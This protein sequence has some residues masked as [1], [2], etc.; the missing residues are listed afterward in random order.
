MVAMVA[1][2][3]VALVPSSVAWVTAQ[4]PGKG[5]AEL[6]G[7]W[8][9]QSVE[10]E[11]EMP[12]IVNYEPRWLI[13]GKKILYAGNELAEITIDT[14]TTPKSID[15]KFL[16]PEKVLEGIYAIDKDTLRICVNTESEGVKERP[17]KFATQGNARLRLLVFQRDTPQTNPTKGIPAFV[18]MM[19]RK[20][21]DGTVVV[22]E[23]FKD[24]PARKAGVKKE[25]VLLQINGTNVADLKGAVE[26]IQRLKPGDQV[27]LRVR[28]GNEERD[29]RITA[30]ALP[31]F[32]L[33]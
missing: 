10:S 13:K 11:Q 22:S 3:L 33:D 2:Y 30:G 27:T 12:K 24:S 1:A 17:A 16:K 28:R 7:T 15:L 23:A 21:K 8:K 31:F 29:I 9:L 14:G 32:L 20:D 4:Q 6:Q 26:T 5:P 18:G 25:D 19:I